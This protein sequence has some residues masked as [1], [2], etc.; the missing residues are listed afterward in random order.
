MAPPVAKPCHWCKRTNGSH[1][2]RC[3]RDP[4]HEA[5]GMRRLRLEAT[6]QRLLADA[7]REAAALRT[8]LVAS[9]ARV[10]VLRELLGA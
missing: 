5:D 7:E 6:V 8:Q 2:A 10:T 1:T 3:P 4:R 9:E